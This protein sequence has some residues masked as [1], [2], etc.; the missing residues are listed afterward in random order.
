VNRLFSDQQPWAGT[1]ASL[2]E[3]ALKAADRC[4]ELLVKNLGAI[5]A[6]QEQFRRIFG[7][8]LNADGVAKAIAGP[9]CTAAAFKA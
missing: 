2:E 1:R 7:T 6:Y 4:P 5:A 9:T 3:Q 8:D